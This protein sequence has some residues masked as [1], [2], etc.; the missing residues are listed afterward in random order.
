M[1][2]SFSD[3]RQKK[4]TA[5]ALAVPTL[6]DPGTDETDT[7]PTLPPRPRKIWASDQE[8]RDAILQWQRVILIQDGKDKGFT[9]ALIR[10]EPE[11]IRTNDTEEYVATGCKI[12]PQA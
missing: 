10:A 6:T 7:T 4:H 11:S 2:Q 3:N 8:A 1:H 9:Q 12:Q 5:E